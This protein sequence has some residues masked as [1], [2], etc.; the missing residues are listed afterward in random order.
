MDF[1]RHQDEARARSF[2]L[3]LLYAVLILA[4][5]FFTAT[6][7]RAVLYCLIDIDSR[8]QPTFSLSLLF[9]HWFLLT[10][11]CLI[12]LCGA[13]YLF[14]PLIIGSGGRD[15]ATALGGRLVPPTT[16][17]QS[18]RRL[19]NVVEEMSLASGIPVPPVYIMEKER[20]IN[21]FAAGNSIN[22]AVLGITRGA[23]TLLDR[24]ELQAVVAHEFSHV[25]NGDMR[26]NLRMARMVFTLTCL[27]QGGSMVLR[28]RH[29]SSRNSIAWAIFLI[30]LICLALGSL[31]A[32]CGKV[33]QGAVCRQR[34]Y[35]ADASS[36]QFTRSLA[37][38]SALKK[39]GSPACGS[40]LTESYASAT[41]SHLCFCRAQAGGIS[42]HPPLKKRILRIDPDWDGLFPQSVEAPANQDRIAPPAHGVWSFSLTGKAAAAEALRIEGLNAPSDSGGAPQATDAG[43]RALHTLLA[44]STTPYEACCLFFAL[45]LNENLAIA[46][47]HIGGDAPKTDKERILEYRRAFDA[48][49]ADEYPPLLEGALPALKMLS[50]RQYRAFE[51]SLRRIIN[52]G[53]GLSLRQWTIGQLIKSQVGWQYPE[54]QAA[55]GQRP[56]AAHL[57]AAALNLLAA[58]AR[59]ETKEVPAEAAYRAGLEAA[60]I[61]PPKAE[62]AGLNKIRDI[63]LTAAEAA[64]LEQSLDTLR[65]AGDEFKERLM[66][67]AVAVVAHD[68]V[69]SRDEAMFLS[70]LSLCLARPVPLPGRAWLAKAV[71][72]D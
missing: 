33:F 46:E 50:E 45:A 70:L 35:L 1:W 65:L 66:L 55:P 27:S 42:S 5:S 9:N 25:L 64:G 54:G 26:L 59:L 44:A 29:N 17:G 8:T 68:Q 15:V 23:L 61:T 72:L 69:L 11:I 40:R 47:R 51:N 32:W 52:A 10:F 20:G 63:P 56:S 3:L 7:I 21:A 30:A 58:L 38:A 31:M 43:S 22:D 48:L 34:E 4:L 67:G 53:P 37:L 71:V 60:A 49:A 14:A 41:Y 36:V 13:L 2:R 57:R 19:L 6:L 12:G 62:A 16:R 39:V 28:M 24:N 18:E